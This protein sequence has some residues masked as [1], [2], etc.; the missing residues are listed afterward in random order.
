MIN[1]AHEARGIMWTSPAVVVP[2]ELPDDDDDA[3]NFEDPSRGPA[4]L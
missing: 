1:G 3:L 2:I 4:S